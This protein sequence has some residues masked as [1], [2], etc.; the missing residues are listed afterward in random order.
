VISVQE[1]FPRSQPSTSTNKSR[2]RAVAR[3]PVTILPAAEMFFL[4][5]HAAGTGD[6]EGNEDLQQ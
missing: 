1:F 5:N 3:L 6:G 4:Q 2:R